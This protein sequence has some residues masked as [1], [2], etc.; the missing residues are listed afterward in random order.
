[1]LSRLR[2]DIRT[3]QQRDP[4][5]CSR[6]WLNVLLNYPGLHAL[7]MHRINHALFG[8][9]LCTLA[10][11]GSQCARF[12]TGI[13]IHPGATIGRR[14]F[15]DHGMGVVIG[16]TSVIGDD[17]TL[18]QGVTLGGTGKQTGKRHPDLADHV[19]VGVGASVLGDI[20]IGENSKVGAGAVV[21]YEVPPN[22]TVVGVPGKIVV[23]DGARIETEHDAEQIR[24]EDLPDPVTDMI[25][26][27]AGRVADLEAQ[28]AQLQGRVAQD[29]RPETVCESGETTGSPGSTEIH[30]RSELVRSNVR[31]SGE[32]DSSC[33]PEPRLRGVVH[34]TL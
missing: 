24:H 8:A 23:R 18:F 15:I 19:T 20:R 4:A 2:E 12:L 22:C 10:R 34:E 5:A 6:S 21:I 32:G 26:F 1:V 27:V 29:N 9:G 11:W 30:S 25:R 13:E 7:W 17:V 33:E 16:E 14:F 28:V 3:V 31:E